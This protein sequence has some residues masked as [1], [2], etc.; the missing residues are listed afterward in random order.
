MARADVTWA[1][2]ASV[3][4]VIWG[5]FGGALQD[6]ALDCDGAVVAVHVQPDP[7]DGSRAARLGLRRRGVWGL[8]SRDTH[9][10]SGHELRGGDDDRRL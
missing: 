2:P 6:L 3:V 8:H 1:I 5:I 9:Q 10:H 4:G 7:R